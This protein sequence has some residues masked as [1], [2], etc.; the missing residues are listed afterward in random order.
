MSPTNH[1][2]PF[3]LF[4]SGAFVSRCLEGHHCPFRSGSSRRQLP[5]LLLEQQVP[6]RREIARTSSW[7]LNVTDDLSQHSFRGIAILYVNL[8]ILEWRHTPLS[9]MH[10]RRGTMIFHCTKDCTQYS[11]V[12]HYCI[13][14]SKTKAQA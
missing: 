8:W 6:T 14:S 1:Q 11:T 10:P 13:S 5:R 12:Q 7:Q 9:A 3:R 4:G 2:F